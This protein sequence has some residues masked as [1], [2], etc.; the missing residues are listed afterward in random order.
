MSEASAGGSVQVRY[1]AAARSA[2]GVESDEVTIGPGATL[3][4]VLADVRH[5]HAAQPKFA[6]VVGCCSVLIGD[7]PVAGLDPATVTVAPGDQV[8]LL[9]PVAG[10]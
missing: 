3:A 8:E 9:P 6:A 10:G 5:R 2:A 1:W 7:R 4:D